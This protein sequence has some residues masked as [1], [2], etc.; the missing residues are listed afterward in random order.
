[1]PPYY[2]YVHMYILSNISLECAS[3][4]CDVADFNTHED[5]ED[6]SQS[7][8]QYKFTAIHFVYIDNTTKTVI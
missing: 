1:M 5:D 7:G 6:D 3:T 8:M 4:K 2:E